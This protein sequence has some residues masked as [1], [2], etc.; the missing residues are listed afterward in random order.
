MVD[1]ETTALTMQ[2]VPPLQ[3]NL[4]Q[5]CLFHLRILRVEKLRAE[6]KL[7]KVLGGFGRVVETVDNDGNEYTD[8][9]VAIEESCRIARDVETRNNSPRDTVHVSRSRYYLPCK[10]VYRR[11]IQ[12]APSS[13]SHVFSWTSVNL[14]EDYK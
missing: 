12:R 9:M 10:V 4:N 8:A 1:V 7:L 3:F 14:Q 11:R 2:I 13:E 5:T 6:E